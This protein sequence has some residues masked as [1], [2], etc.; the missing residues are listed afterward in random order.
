MHVENCEGF[1]GGKFVFPPRLHPR[2]SEAQGS[3]IVRKTEHFLWTGVIPNDLVLEVSF[4]LANEMKKRPPKPPE[5]PVLVC[6]AHGRSGGERQEAGPVVVGQ[7]EDKI[8]TCPA[9][10]PGELEIGKPASFGSFFGVGISSCQD[11][12]DLGATGENAIAGF[13]HEDPDFGVGEFL[14]GSDDSRGKQERITDVAKLDEENTPW[15]RRE[16]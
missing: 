1:S 14:F 6:A 16:R 15:R 8:K 3:R 5:R 12:V 7:F 9:Q 2:L 13:A 10:Q 11:P 4:G